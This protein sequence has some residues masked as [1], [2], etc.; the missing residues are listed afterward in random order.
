MNHTKYDMINLYIWKILVKKF[1]ILFLPF[2]LL[3]GLLITNPFYTYIEYVKTAPHWFVSIIYIII[4]VAKFTY[5]F[6]FARHIV[7]LYITDTIMKMCINSVINKNEDET[8]HNNCTKHNQKCNVSHLCHTCYPRK[9]IWRMQDHIALIVHIFLGNLLFQTIPYYI[10]YDHMWFWWYVQSYWKGYV[11]LQH[12]FTR[13]GCCPGSMISAYRYTPIYISGFVLGAVGTTLD[14]LC[15]KHIPSKTLYW[16]FM[17]FFEFMIALYV[18]EITIKYPIECGMTEKYKQ[19]LLTVNTNNNNNT[20]RLHKWLNL[21]SPIWILWKVSQML[22]VGF[23]NIT[24]RENITNTPLDTF[25][26]M[27]E[28][29]KYFLNEWFVCFI[30]RIFLWKEYRSYRS[31][32][33]VGPTAPYVRTQIM[34]IFN[35]ICAIRNNLKDYNKQ[36]FVLKGIASTPVLGSWMRMTL[37]STMKNVSTILKKVGPMKKLNIFIEQILTEL[38]EPLVHGID[39]NID[40]NDN[41]AML[42][43]DNVTPITEEYFEGSVSDNKSEVDII[44]PILKTNNIKHHNMTQRTSRNSTRSTAVVFQNSKNELIDEKILSELQDAIRTIN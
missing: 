32:V 12:V 18:Q 31:F 15:I 11:Y 4:Y 7:N 35:I 43:Y 24:K 27:Y 16:F 2:E 21:L 33:T 44:Q 1:L 5:L 20:I 13:D 39:N 28:R 37:N 38:Q 23:V 8:I 36:L 29:L 10:R 22:V 19:T 3:F 30:R 14:I 17:F 25:I 42:Y 9:I 6:M 26:D 34:I 40:E 41:I